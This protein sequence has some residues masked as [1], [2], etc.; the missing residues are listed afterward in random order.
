MPSPA[1]IRIEK[2][3]RCE[4]GIDDILALLLT[5]SAQP[6]EAELLLI[7][8]TFGNIEVRSCLR[9][10]VS[11]FHVLEREMQWRREQGRPEGFGALRAC[12]PVVAV[13]AEDP[14]EDQKM[15]ADYFHGTDG[16]GGIHASVC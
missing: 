14:L 12:R 5:L 10:V 1:S 8:L 2:L 6:E 3:T 15:L 9:N 4:Q 13:G 16:L 7:S 11:M